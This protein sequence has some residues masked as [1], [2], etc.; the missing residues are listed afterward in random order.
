M[1]IFQM[2]EGDTGLPAVCAVQHVRKWSGTG[3]E[4]LQVN[5]NYSG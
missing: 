4:S 2:G 5:P 1:V 3:D